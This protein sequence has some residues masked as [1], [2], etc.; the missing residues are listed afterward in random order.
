[1]IKKPLPE[2]VERNRSL[3]PRDFTVVATE[4]CDSHLLPRKYNIV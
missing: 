2:S 1:M 4:R 3:R